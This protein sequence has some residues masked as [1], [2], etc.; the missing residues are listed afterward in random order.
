MPENQLHSDIAL[1]GGTNATNGN[2]FISGSPVCDDGWDLNAANVACRRYSHLLTGG[3]IG[4]GGG[5]VVNA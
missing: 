1:V 5:A 2:V 4:G 3:D